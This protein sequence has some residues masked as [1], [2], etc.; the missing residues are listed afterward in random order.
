MSKN[1]DVLRR[2]WIAY[3]HS[4]YAALDDGRMDYPPIPADL[5]DLRCGARTRA[6]TPCKM[7]CLYRS[8]RCKLH[9]GMSTGPRSEEGKAKSSQNAKRVRVA[10]EPLE[11]LQKHEIDELQIPGKQVANQSKPKI[12]KRP[13]AA[14]A[15]ITKQLDSKA[16][17]QEKWFAW[18]AERR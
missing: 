14:W 10:N 5:H 6:G 18:C 11:G 8:G 13:G 17:V 16:S 9:G 15:E 2:K 3:W 12:T 4:R 1:N 7:K